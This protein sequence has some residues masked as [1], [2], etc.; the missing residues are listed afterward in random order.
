MSPAKRAHRGL[1]PLPSNGSTDQNTTKATQSQVTGA[2]PKRVRRQ[3]SWRSPTRGAPRKRPGRRLATGRSNSSARPAPATLKARE[4]ALRQ[5]GGG[6]GR[7]FQRCPSNLS[8]ST[9]MA[10]NLSAHSDHLE[11]PRTPEQRRPSGG[12]GSPKPAEDSDDGLPGPTQMWGDESPGVPTPAA[13]WS[14][15]RRSSIASA[16]SS[17]RASTGSQKERDRSAERSISPP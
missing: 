2:T 8:T 3:R 12:L 17:R 6:I 9:E 13:L 7:Y 15:R 11:A 10:N 16:R 5:T 1:R 4:V 14:R